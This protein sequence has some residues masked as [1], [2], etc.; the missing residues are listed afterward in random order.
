MSRVFLSLG[1]NLGNRED[2]LARALALLSE[3]VDVVRRSSV[4]ETEPVGYPDQPW[5]LNMVTKGE[6]GLPP[7]ELLSFTQGIE[8]KLKRVKTIVN[9]PRTIDL[10]ILLYED[11]RMETERL[12]IPHPRMLTRAFVMV[13]L[14]EIAPEL[15][16]NGRTVGEIMKTFTG[17]EIHKRKES[18]G[19]NQPDPD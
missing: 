19:K 17:E 11:Q 9:G 6:T 12:T 7:E 3:K 1:T 5:F 15:M 18:Y 14:L 4:Y 8:R 16:I 13:P 2:N 10:D